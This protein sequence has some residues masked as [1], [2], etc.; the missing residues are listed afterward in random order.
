MTRLRSPNGARDWRSPVHKRGDLQGNGV[1]SVGYAALD[2]GIFLDNFGHASQQV[3]SKWP[4]YGELL[5]AVIKHV[6]W[7]LS[8]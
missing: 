4:H 1:G 5:D 3:Q 7:C 6:F 8:G 2:L